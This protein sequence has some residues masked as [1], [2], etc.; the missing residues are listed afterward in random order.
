MN[1]TPKTGPD[2]GGPLIVILG[3][4]TPGRIF[5]ECGIFQGLAG[6]A[7]QALDNLAGRWFGFYPLALRF[8]LRHGLNLDRLERMAHFIAGQMKNMESVKP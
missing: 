5:M 1:V 6:R 2:R 7:A 4:V 3:G 8:N